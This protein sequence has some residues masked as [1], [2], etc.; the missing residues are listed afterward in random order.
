LFGEKTAQDVLLKLPHRQFVFTLPKALR[1]FF[2]HDRLLFSD[3]ST[4]IFD[5]IQL[6]YDEVSSKKIKT[7]LILSYQTSGDFARFH[8]HWHGLLIEGGFDE[9]FNFVEVQL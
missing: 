4:L 3:I 2:K 8:P 7:G 5:M 6:Y 9:V 1:V